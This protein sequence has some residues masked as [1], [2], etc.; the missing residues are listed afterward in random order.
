MTRVR[1]RKSY[2]IFIR[3]HT[4]RHNMSPLLLDGLPA[5]LMPSSLSF[6]ILTRTDR[7]CFLGVPMLKAQKLRENLVT[8]LPRL[9]AVLKDCG[10]SPRGPLQHF[11]L[12]LRL[13][14]MAGSP[15]NINVEACH[16][17]PGNPIH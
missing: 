1:D 4:N 12:L 10:I 9:I 5:S 17:L 16:I 8:E 11:E 13:N 6:E 14:M 2:A 7:Y 15:T 3:V